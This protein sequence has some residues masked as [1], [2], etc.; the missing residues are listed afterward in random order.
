MKIKAAHMLAFVFLAALIVSVSATG[1]SS[2]IIIGNQGGPTISF[3]PSGSGAGAG[4]TI[5]GGFSLTYPD[6][7]PVTLATNPITIEAC[8]TGGCVSI[9]VTVTP[10]PNPGQ[11]TFTFTAGSDFPTGTVTL[12][13]PAG[14]LTDSSGD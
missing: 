7:K 13:I 1:Y 4:G 8:G 12:T 5:T 3:T 6:G 11:Y 10:G 2:G 9:Q 14:S